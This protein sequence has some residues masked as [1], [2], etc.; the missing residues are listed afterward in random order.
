MPRTTLP[1]FDPLAELG[2][3]RPPSDRAKARPTRQ[4]RS[5][6]PISE[7]S[8][9]SPD[10]AIAPS[11]EPA[12]ATSEHDEAPVKASAQ[13]A[14]SQPTTL[15]DSRGEHPRVRPRLTLASSTSPSTAPQRAKTSGR[16]SAT[17]FEE[18]RDCV[19]WHGHAMTIDSFTEAAFREHLKRLRRQHDLGDR[20]PTREREPKQGRRVS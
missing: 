3:G 13:I 15:D 16:I 17:V 14:V 4:T 8:R 2:I 1:E 11:S 20:F 7:P 18:V 12:I 5:P 9:S 10:A 6:E 19:V